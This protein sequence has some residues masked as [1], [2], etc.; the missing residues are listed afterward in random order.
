MDT[1]PPMPT[2]T[3][4]PSVRRPPR[5]TYS[6]EFKRRVVEQTLQPG[7]SVALIAREHGMNANVIFEWRRQFRA[8]LAD[9]TAMTQ[10][11]NAMIPVNVIE[12]TASSLPEKAEPTIAQACH[13]EVE[14]GKRRVRIAG[15]TAAQ[16]M[17]FLHEC[18]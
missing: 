11:V 9:G 3:D 6:P 14:I 8:G 7:A 17:Q 13:V 18:L 5:R 2:I 15:L 10:P 1:I 16:A 4:T 12:T